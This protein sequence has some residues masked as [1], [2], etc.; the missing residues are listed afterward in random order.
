MGLFDQ[1]SNLS[2]DQNQGLLAA[3]ASLLQSGGP[4]RMPVSFGQALGGGLTAYQQSTDASRRR[5][6]EE[7]Q[8]AQVAKLTGLKIKDAESDLS[9]Q[10][11]MRDRAEQLRQFYIGNAAGGAAGAGSSEAEPA[12]ASAAA[13][14]SG[15]SGGQNMGLYQQRLAMAQ[16]LRDAGFA[17]EADAQEASALKFQPKVKGW[18]KVQQ[19][20]KVLFA[21][22]FEDGTSGAP[23][24]LEVAEKLEKINTGGKTELANPYTGAT[25]RTLQNTQTPDSIASVA[26]T[27]QGQKLANDRG[28]EANEIARGRLAVDKAPTEF[29]GKSA[30]YGLRAREADKILNEVQGKYSPAKINAKNAVSEWP[31]VGGA[32]GAIQNNTLSDTDQKAEQAQRNFVNAV[33]RQESGAAISPSEFENAKKQYFP[34]PGDSKAVI[35]Q[36][37]VNRKLAIQGFDSN[38]GRAKIMAPGAAATGGWKIQQVD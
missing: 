12:V 28:I 27:L 10:S 9:N 29:Q 23:V 21:P 14:T 34:Q 15:G 4:S 38:A 8:A 3:A 13:P 33:L 19:G 30:A 16:K 2:P 7:E 22:F 1:F 37:D 24:P 31:I 35:A 36:K 20:G 6:L 17:T 18:E 11:A 26:A 5:K 32:L 25:V